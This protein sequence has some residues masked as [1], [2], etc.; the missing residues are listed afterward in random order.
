MIQ[1]ISIALLLRVAATGDNVQRNPPPGE[2]IEGRCLTGGQR[3]RHKA[4]TVRNQETQ[5][6]CRRGHIPGNGEAIGGLKVVT[7]NGWFAVRPSGTEDAYKLYAESFHDRVHLARIQGE[8]QAL[9]GRVFAQGPTS[10]HA[11]HK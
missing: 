9:I 7:S 5:A 4:R 8:A 3:G 10:G 1:P 2:V 6:L 11:P